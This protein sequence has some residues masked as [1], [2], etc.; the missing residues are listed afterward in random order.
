MSIFSTIC[1]EYFN[2][3]INWECRI[4]RFY[5]IK[6]VYSSTSGQNTL[7]I[8]MRHKIGV[9]YLANNYL[10]DYI[11]KSSVWFILVMKCKNSC[12]IFLI[13]SKARLSF[14]Y[15]WILKIQNCLFREI[16]VPVMLLQVRLNLKTILAK[17]FIN[18]GDCSALGTENFR[19]FFFD[20]VTVAW[21]HQSMKSYIS[22][23]TASF[24]HHCKIRKW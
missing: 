1:Y 3:W 19:H 23:R 6:Y 15:K 22:V 10:V 24:K 11:S 21:R 14:S 9:Y 16:S 2:F 7:Y 5:N 4:W 17:W 12:T 20:R 8:Y 13:L 18:V